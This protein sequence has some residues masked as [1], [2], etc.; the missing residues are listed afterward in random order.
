MVAF[1]AGCG[2]ARL[3]AA[4]IVKHHQ[5]L[6]GHGGVALNDLHIAGKR[7]FLLLVAHLERGG[8]DLDRLIAVLREALHRVGHALHRALRDRRTRCDQCDADGERGRTRDDAPL[9]VVARKKPDHE[10]HFELADLFWGVR[11]FA[12]G[13][14][15]VGAG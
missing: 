9:A 10:N 15:S 4:R 5:R 3:V 1:A 8:L 7:R 13:A 14:G 2:A 11:V 6:R 12:A